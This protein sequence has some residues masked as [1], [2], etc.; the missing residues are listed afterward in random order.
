[1]VDWR[2]SFPMLRRLLPCLF[3][4]TGLAM[5]QPAPLTL[6]LQ[7]AQ[8]RAQMNAPQLLAALSDARVAAEDIK[9]ARAGQRPYASFKSDYLGTQGNGVIPTGRFVTNDGVHVYRD[10]GL[11]HQDVM[12]ALTHTAVDKA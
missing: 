4:G 2:V 11:V 8:T 3:A 10:W 12:A 9:Q 5:A 7:D 6:T 1:M